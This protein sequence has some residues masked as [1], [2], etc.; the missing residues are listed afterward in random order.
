MEAGAIG[1]GGKVGIE[2]AGGL[3][4]AALGMGFMKL[5]GLK[6]AAAV[7]GTAVAGG[8]GA[9]VAG[10][11]TAAAAAGATKIGLVWSGLAKAGAALAAKVTGAGAGIAGG[12]SALAGG[13]MM[14]LGAGAA[15][16]GGGALIGHTIHREV[17]KPMMEADF[18]R[19]ES[20]DEVLAEIQR[21]RKMESTTLG[22]KVDAL[23]YLKK[24]MGELKEGPSVWTGMIGE[25]ASFFT[26]AKP[27]TEAYQQQMEAIVEEEFKLKKSITDQEEAL[28]ENRDNLKEFAESVFNASEA[29]RAMSQPESTGTGSW[30]RTGATQGN[31]WNLP[32]KPGAETKGAND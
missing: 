15:A 9:G 29:L 25:I 7:A 10:A 24:R 5:F 19:L 12:G 2:V 4:A 32:N 23:G 26:D 3:G 17:T 28:R 22:E 20:I 21:V 18:A 13:A 14:T 8:T 30:T 1:V 31:L 6:S 11:G 27:A 16:A